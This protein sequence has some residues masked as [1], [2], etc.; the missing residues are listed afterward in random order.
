MSQAGPGR[1]KSVEFL[2]ESTAPKLKGIASLLKG[3]VDSSKAFIRGTDSQKQFNNQFGNFCRTAVVGVSDIEE[4]LWRAE[5]ERGGAAG[6]SINVTEASFLHDVCAYVAHWSGG[7]VSQAYLD[8]IVKSS[9]LMTAAET[10]NTQQRVDVEAAKTSKKRQRQAEKPAVVSGGHS[11][12]Y[13][14]LS[15]VGALRPTPFALDGAG[16]GGS[17]A[18]KPQSKLTHNPAYQPIL[19]PWTSSLPYTHGVVLDRVGVER[20]YHGAAGAS[21]VAASSQQHGS[22]P[23]ILHICSCEHPHDMMQ[24]W[25]EREAFLSSASTSSHG[26]TLGMRTASSTASLK[27]VSLVMSSSQHPD[28]SPA[29]RPAAPPAEQPLTFF[30]SADA[31]DL[32]D[33]A[34]QAFLVQLVHFG[35]TSVEPLLRSTVGGK[36]ATN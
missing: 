36:G 32:V 26:D 24:R 16:V 11:P 1:S 9:R 4:G 23:A 33:A 31:S 27:A 14:A 13:N 7:K 29:I 8:G 15:P 21:Q 28:E 3:C 18:H 35:V 25:E 30:P 22:C 34:P 12:S 10:R 5:E 20:H 6:E 17:P 19:M 2:L